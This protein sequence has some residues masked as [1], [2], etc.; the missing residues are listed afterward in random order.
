LAAALHGAGTRLGFVHRAALSREMQKQLSDIFHSLDE[1]IRTAASSTTAWHDVRAL[2]YEAAK[3]MG[4]E[5]T[6]WHRLVRRY[7]DE[8]P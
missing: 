3:A 2:A 5:N 1:L 4:V 8:L 6:S 7:R